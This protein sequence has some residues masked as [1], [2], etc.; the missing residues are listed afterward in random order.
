[1]AIAK[2][3]SGGRDAFWRLSSGDGAHI[4]AI[5]YER[6]YFSDL[7]GGKYDEAHT[8]ISWPSGYRKKSLLG[9]ADKKMRDHKVEAADVYSD[10]AT[11]YLRLI[12]A[13]RLNANAALQS[14]SWGKFQIM[15]Q[16]F[17][18]CGMRSAEDFVKKMC[19]SESGQIQ[20]LTGFIRKKPLAWK[21]P[22]NKALGKEISL[23][24]AVKTKNWRAIAF[25]YNGPGYETYAY[26][27]KLENAYEA[28]RV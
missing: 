22:K 23:W 4:P 13:Y 28:S 24:D 6:H 1:M 26:H 9:T 14:C 18:L 2:V 19:E 15:G 25:N 11:S 20:L 27:T 12:N 17:K 10:Y 21:N 5:L 7:T 8:D 16:N 3:E